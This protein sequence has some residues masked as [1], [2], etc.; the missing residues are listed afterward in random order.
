MGQGVTSLLD[1][2]RVLCG[3]CD[4]EIGADADLQEHLDN[5]CEWVKASDRMAAT[6]EKFS[7]LMDRI[8]L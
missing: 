2:C 7:V 5:D 1:G 6:S 8:K 4:V 3:F